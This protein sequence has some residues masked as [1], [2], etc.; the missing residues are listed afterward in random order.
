MAEAFANRVA[1]IPPNR[2]H[3]GS[4]ARDA[5]EQ[6]QQQERRRLGI[7]VASMSE[8]LTGERQNDYNQTR[9]RSE[10]E[11]IQHRLIDRNRTSPP[12]GGT[13]GPRGGGFMVG[14]PTPARTK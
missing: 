8:Q 6:Q 11:D 1:P 3:M 10:E 14:D 4:Q 2:H 7:D 5:P 13:K 9:N 12:E